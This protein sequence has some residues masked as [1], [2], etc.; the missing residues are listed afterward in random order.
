MENMIRSEHPETLANESIFGIIIQLREMHDQPVCFYSAEKFG[1]CIDALEQRAVEM[2][3]E[4]VSL[5]ARLNSAFPICTMGAELHTACTNGIKEAEAETLAYLVRQGVIG[6]RDA[7]K[8]ERDGMIKNLRSAFELLNDCE[9]EEA[10]ESNSA[11]Y[12]FRDKRL[13]GGIEIS[14]TR[15]LASM[16]SRS[17]YSNGVHAGY[18]FYGAI[19]SGGSIVNESQVAE[20]ILSLKNSATDFS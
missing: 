7:D 1:W 20:I 19:S 16:F 12:S 10:K 2:A 8:T 5:K 18:L 4:I 6:L 17:Y 15:P 13:H 9:P 14:P 3:D 11:Q